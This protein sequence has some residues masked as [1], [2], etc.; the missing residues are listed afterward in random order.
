MLLLCLRH[1]SAS[2]IQTWLFFGP[3]LASESLGLQSLSAGLLFRRA[4]E[5]GWCRKR[6]NFLDS[7]P[8]Q[9]PTLYFLSSLR[10]PRG[11]G[12]DSRLC[13]PTTCQVMTKLAEPNH[14][15]PDCQCQTV[16]GP[17]EPVLK[18]VAAGGIPPIRIWRV[19]S[20]SFNLEV[21]PYS[22]A[23]RF[24]AI[25]HVWADRQLGSNKNAL[26]GCQV[27]YLNSVLTTL[28]RIGVGVR[29][30]LLDCW[31]PEGI[32]APGVD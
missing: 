8:T 2:V 18:I 17:L 7:V 3:G 25:S 19:S 21:F 5:S 13:M 15:P 26:P 20:G 12:E 10:P 24:V 9:Y 23:I 27:E 4:V 28:P 1:P 31:R 16:Q 22:R 29:D 6:L 32:R 30:M 11:R 14:R